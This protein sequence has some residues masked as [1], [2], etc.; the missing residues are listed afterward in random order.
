MGKNKQ[1]RIGYIDFLKF[2]GLTGIIIAHV[3]SPNWLMGLRSFDVPFM[4]ILS[5]ILGEKS[6]LKKKD[7]QISIFQY[8]I[9][10][11]KRL[12]FPT[13]LFLFF[14]FSIVFVISGSLYEL[15]YYIASFSLTRYG[16]GYVWVI[17]MYLYSAVLIPV[18]SK[19]QLSK[20]GMF[21]V[22]I[23]YILYEISYYFQIGVNN[24]LID[25]TFYYFIPYGV[26]TYLGCN[27]LHLK[28]KQKVLIAIIAFAL[29]I[30]LGSYYWNVFGAPQLVS[31]SKYPPRLYYLA[32]GV[33]ISFFLLIICE[34]SSLKIYDNVF[35]SFISRNSLWI[36][37][38][39]VLTLQVYNF[40]HLPEIWFVKLF[41]VYISSI[42][43]VVIVNKLIDILEKKKRYRILKYLKA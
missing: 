34:N 23:I 36:Y 4:V 42:I 12:V 3:G 9:C 2:I 41:V 25:T 38:W 21:Y 39:H 30:V 32:Y 16:I 13:W 18:F 11:F 26:L 43:I 37:L 24:K 17:L 35:I 27:Y 5:A 15:E 19:I 28:K 8:Y 14:Y 6:Y 10:R 29:F 7:N 40:L 31:I 33:A 22:A 1:F 20:W